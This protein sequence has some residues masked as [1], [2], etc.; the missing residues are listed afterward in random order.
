MTDLGQSGSELL[1]PDGF[2]WAVGIEDTF[3]GR[4]LRHSGRV[5]DEYVLTQHDRFWREDLDRAAAMG[6][7]AIRWGVPW[8]RVNPAPGVFDWSWVDEVLTYATDARDLTVIADLVHY[9]TPLWLEGSFFDP[10]YP[11]AVAEYAGAFARRY[12]ARV[13]HY[14]PLNE[15]IHTASFCGERGVWPPYLEGPD[16]WLKVVFGVVAGIRASIAAIRAEDP[17][18]VIVHVEE[19]KVL[20][21]AAAE[22][23]AELAMER[24]RNFFPTDLLLGRVDELHPLASWLIS[25]GV[26]AQLAEFQSDP[27]V[28]DVLGVNF[29]PEL[30]TRELVPLE[31][32]VVQVAFDGWA[33]GLA[34]AVRGFH[35]RYG[36]PILVAE[37]STEGDDA[38]RVAW[39][40]AAAGALER[41]R[42]EGVPVRGLT[43]WPMFDLVDWTYTAGGSSVEEF[44]VR[45]ADRCGVQHI[46]AVPP[47]GASHDGIGAFI[48]PMGAWRLVPALDGVLCREE[49]PLVAEFRKL[50]CPR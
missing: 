12:R 47:K 27:P 5:L 32:S 28:L 49:T 10:D 42:G 16:G 1:N 20:T 14:T 26:A 41:L 18:A 40:H 6:A 36:L 22:L 8:Y 39:L 48:R 33:D 44:H 43:W 30:S 34:A 35:D 13:H 25:H 19:S 11:R 4:P 24:E 17:E 50:A 15:P 38:R 9:G 46:V 29:Y 2:V 3:I 21:T 31:G 45:V 37:T 7:S 23:S